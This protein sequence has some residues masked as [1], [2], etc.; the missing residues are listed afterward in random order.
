ML[1]EQAQRPG[2]VSAGACLLGS[3]KEIHFQGQ[4]IFR[5]RRLNWSRDRPRSNRPWG[6]CPSG[7]TASGLTLSFDRRRLRLRLIGRLC[8]RRCRYNDRSWDWGR[9]LDHR[10]RGRRFGL[11]PF[12]FG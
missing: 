4:R 3:T 8:F 10:R 2:M 5:S 11:I 6:R 1:V 7:G 12:T 9:R